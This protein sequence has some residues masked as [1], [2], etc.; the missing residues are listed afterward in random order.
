M[1]YLI[2]DTNIWIYLAN[3]FSTVSN[4]ADYENDNHIEVF[5]KIK[6]QQ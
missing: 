1:I 3:G 5:N 6:S 4:S 2:I